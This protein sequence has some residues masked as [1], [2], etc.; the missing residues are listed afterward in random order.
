MDYF[1]TLKD[2]KKLLKNGKEN[3]NEDDVTPVSTSNDSPLD[4]RY[5]LIGVVVFIILS[6]PFVDSLICL[7]FG[8]T[9]S[10]ITI[11]LVKIVLFIIIF[12]VVQLLII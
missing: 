3:K 8:T 11:W 7:Q 10:L 2:V 12:Y 6:M 1:N 5:A 9:A 4:I